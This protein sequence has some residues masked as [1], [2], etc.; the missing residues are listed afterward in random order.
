MNSSFGSIST[1]KKDYNTKEER[2]KNAYA[3]DFDTLQVREGIL[4][5]KLTLFFF[6]ISQKL[7][8]ELSVQ[9]KRLKN[10]RAKLDKIKEKVHSTQH[11]IGTIT[12]LA[13]SPDLLS[14][15]NI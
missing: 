8:D 14:H 6:I 10:E 9:R 11:Q 2:N 5:L 7:E 15:R 13:G 3:E 4:E 12:N 1:L